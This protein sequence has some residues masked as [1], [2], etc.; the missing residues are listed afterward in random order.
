MRLRSATP[1]DAAALIELW[2]ESWSSN[3]FDGPADIR[4]MMAERVPRELGG[5]WEVTV[6][7][8]DGRLLGFLALAMAEQRLD[9]LFIAPDAQGQGVGA[10]LFAVA[11][12][13]LPDGFWLATQV[14]NARARGFYERRGMVL[15]R[16]EEDR[17]Y[18]RL[19]P[20]A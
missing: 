20:I 11:V 9:Q 12:P 14:E 10:A 1:E 18:Y 3:G 4:E 19:V 16:F 13:R 17:A 6:A 15:D 5:R 7:E 2:F 8:A